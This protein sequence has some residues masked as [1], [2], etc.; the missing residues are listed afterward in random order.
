[1]MISSFFVFLMI[2]RPPRSTRTDTLFPDTTLFRSGRR[3][4]RERRLG[5]GSCEPAVQH[6]ASLFPDR[7]E[8]PGALALRGF[9]DVVVAACVVAVPPAAF[10]ALGAGDDARARVTQRDGSGQQPC[11]ARRTRRR[12]SEEHTSELQSLMRISYAVFCL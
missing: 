12:R 8:G 11:R 7:G 6:P 10:E 4:Y 1:M 3:G 2:R 5:E 9:D